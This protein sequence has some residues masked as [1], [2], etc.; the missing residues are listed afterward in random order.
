MHSM[1]S[2]SFSLLENMACVAM[3]ITL[4]I[5]LVCHSK[6]TL[7]TSKVENAFPAN[8]PFNTKEL[9]YTIRFKDKD[10]DNIQD[11]TVER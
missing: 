5:D 1:F 7:N 11:P 10:Y 3:G 8:L 2:M 6:P 9:L 4:I